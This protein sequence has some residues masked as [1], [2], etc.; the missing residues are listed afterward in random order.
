MFFIE[1][2]RRFLLLFALCAL[3]P[4]LFLS[5]AGSNLLFFV[6][7]VKNDISITNGQLDSSSVKTSRF[8]NI[9]Q[10]F[11]FSLNNL[12]Y[13][14]RNREN[15]L[16][17]AK[18][19]LKF[20]KFYTA[21]ELASELMRINSI[22]SSSIQ[23]GKVLLIPHTI[24][25]FSQDLRNTKK[26]KIINAKGLY[27]TASAAGRDSIIPTVDKFRSKG[28]NTI[29]FDIKD[30]EGTLSFSSSN[31][32]AKQLGL[33]KRKTISNMSKLIIELKKRNIYTIARIAC[34]RD[35][36]V[37]K[38]RP[39][40]AVKSR[41]TGRIWNESSNELWL[42]PTNKYTQEYIT[43]LAIEVSEYGVDE[44]QL[45]YIRFPT[46]SNLGDAVF[47]WHFGKM[48]KEEAIT[49]FLKKIYTEMTLRNTNLSIDIFGVVAWGFEGDIDKTGQRISLLA[50]YCD[51]ISPM[52]YPSHFN[53]NF[54]GFRNPG[55]NPYYFIQ[56]GV[57]LVK[58]DAGTTFVRPWLQ[59]FGWR[60][61]SYDEKY[62]IEQ[63]SASDKAGAAG[64][65]FWN[66]SSNY[67][68]VYNALNGSN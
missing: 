60:V 58:K 15:I 20:T 14:T 52:L 19:S 64:Y 8:R 39:D 3:I 62:I 36:I 54:D 24:S 11:C 35:H 44:I 49:F 67:D 47:A 53:D 34:F 17:V 22:K 7:S 29:V 30:V 61:S 5:G 32:L 6:S 9:P 45:D 46:A 51:V 63:T 65:L 21:K 27:L 31:P 4:V 50:K 55:D 13:T 33:D 57:E 68:K 25:A 12:F 43:N 18:K 26:S 38:M 41:S 59:A 28:I 23:P 16:D 48:K 56:K 66:A 10:D 1:F 37:A 2:M 40:L 42:D